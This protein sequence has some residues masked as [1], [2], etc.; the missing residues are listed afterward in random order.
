[1]KR[2]GILG[3]SGTKK[4]ESNGNAMCIIVL[5]MLQQIIPEL[6]TLNSMSLLSYSSGSQIH[7][8]SHGDKIKM[9]AGLHSFLEVLGRE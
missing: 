4:K 1:M 7:N 2:W 6:V 3:E 5:L 9:L 8:E